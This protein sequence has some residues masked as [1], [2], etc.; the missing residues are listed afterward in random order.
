MYSKDIYKAI[1][2]CGWESDEFFN[3]NDADSELELHKTP[4]WSDYLGR[5]VMPEGCSSSS[6]YRR[7]MPQ[8]WSRVE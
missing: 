5:Y 2:N 7:I 3:P 8:G 4:D 6:I 1:C